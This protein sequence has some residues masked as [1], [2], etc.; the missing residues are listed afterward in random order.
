[1]LLSLPLPDEA[2]RQVPGSAKLFQQELRQFAAVRLPFMALLP[3]YLTRS[4]AAS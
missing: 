1:M 2:I 3:L 4:T